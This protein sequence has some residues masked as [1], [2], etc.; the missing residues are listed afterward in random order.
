MPSETV[1]AVNWMLFTSLNFFVLQK[2]I[3]KYKRQPN[4][5]QS[6]QSIYIWPAY[7]AWLGWLYILLSYHVF[8]IDE[9]VIYSK[10]V[11]SIPDADTAHDSTN[12]TE[13][14]NNA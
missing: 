11:Q 10:E 9:G 5:K 2:L 7:L 13:T 14:N 12:S 6:Y 3:Y 1:T 4:Y 8:R